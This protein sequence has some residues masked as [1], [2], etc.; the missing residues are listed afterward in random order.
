MRLFVGEVVLQHGREAAQ[1]GVD[2]ARVGGSGRADGGAVRVDEDGDL[3][4]LGFEAC[5]DWSHRGVVL[6]EFGEE[7]GGF[8]VMMEVQV[9]GVLLT[10]AHEGL[11]AGFGLGAGQFMLAVNEVFDVAE[12]VL[13]FAAKHLVDMQE[14]TDKRTLQFLGGCPGVGLAS[15][16]KYSLENLKSGKDKDTISG[17]RRK[18]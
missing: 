10:G 4:V 8:G 18:F 5:D 7:H 16:R 6:D 2:D 11:D 14:F 13:H 9:V 1:V 15:Q 3:V 12:H 17:K